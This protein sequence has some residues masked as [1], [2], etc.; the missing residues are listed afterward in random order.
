M[1]DKYIFIII[2]LSCSIFGLFLGFMKNNV[3]NDTKIEEYS[4]KKDINIT[5]DKKKE[6]MDEKDEE[7]DEEEESDIED[8]IER[9]ENKK[10]II[11]KKLRIAAGYS[12]DNKYC[13]PT[14]VAMTSLAETA[15]PKTYY[16]IYVL[17]T[18]DFTKDNKEIL[19]S[20]EKRHYNKCS[21]ILINMGNRFVG[22]KVDHLA[23]SAYY[24]LVFHDVVP[25]HKR[26]I[27]MDGDTMVR[28]D[29]TDLINLD[30]KDKYILGFLDS[31]QSAIEK[32]GIKNATVLC[33][34]IL[35]IDLESLRKFNYTD[36]INDFI[37]KNRD[38][39]NQHDQTIINVVFQ[40]KLAPIPPKYGM[41]AFA[42]E[43]SVDE[44]LGFQHSWNNYNKKEFYEAWR[45]PSIVHWIWPKP[46][47][48]NYYPAFNE[49]WWNN[50]IKTGYIDQ[51]NEFVRIYK[52]YSLLFL[53]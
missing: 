50:A 21:V 22:L 9:H 33:S 27:Y 42:D 32:F 36:K 46:F 31:V 6:K 37:E 5:S 35:L 48:S 26:I 3:E 11:G 41:W 24:R 12:T 49:E 20:V 45:D 7:I 44:H 2:V 14:L 30:M 1:N 18:P 13:Y 43:W 40:D 25:N 10:K 16:E 38:R 15:G 47:W 8:E 23:T 19:R 51:I 17:H 4:I 52:R 53:R 34:G 28:H 29:L 39:L